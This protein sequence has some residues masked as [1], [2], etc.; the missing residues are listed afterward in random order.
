MQFSP[1]HCSAM[2]EKKKGGGETIKKIA[3][4]EDEPG[5]SVNAITGKP[6]ANKKIALHLQRGLTVCSRLTQRVS[7]HLSVSCQKILQR[8]GQ[9]GKDHTQAQMAHIWS[10]IRKRKKST[11]QIH[12]QV[13]GA[14]QGTCLGRATGMLLNQW[15]VKEQ[16]LLRNNEELAQVGQ[17]GDKSTGALLSSFS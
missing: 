17:A 6:H 13:F 8:A 7:A 12:R 2:E 10:K 4:I 15:L 14:S 5:M 1:N 11:S 16:T 9:L 3:G